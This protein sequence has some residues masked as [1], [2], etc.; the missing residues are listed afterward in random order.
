MAGLG[1]GRELAWRRRQSRRARTATFTLAPCARVAALQ[2][3]QLHRLAQL[4]QSHN[5]IILLQLLHAALQYCG[6]SGDTC[7]CPTRPLPHT[8]CCISAWHLILPAS[9]MPGRQ[10]LVHT[11]W[12]LSSS[13]S[14]HQ[15]ASRSQQGHGK[16]SS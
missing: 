4:L 13:W 6:A 15:K 7:I 16:A 1:V 2:L 9:A 14:R 10:C 12:L 11:T 3:L 8:V 5:Y